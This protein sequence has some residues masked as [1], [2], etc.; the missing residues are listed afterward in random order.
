MHQG[1]L[2][3]QRATITVQAPAK[4][5][6]T[7]AITGLLNNG[8]HQVKTLMQSISLSDT[9]K[10][11]FSPAEGGSI[12]LYLDKGSDA[13]KELFPLDDSNLIVK[14][15]DHLLEK[16]GVKR[17]FDVK[18]EVKKVIPI[19]AGLAGGSSNAAASLVAVNRYLGNP[20]KSADLFKLAASLG[21]DVPFCLLGGTCIG[22]NIGDV[23]NIVENRS[24]LSFVLAKP[25]KLSVSTPLAYRLFDE[26]L[27]LGL[28]F[29][30]PNLEEAVT[31]LEFDEL[32]PLLSSMGNMF[33][34]V[35]LESYPQLK[36]LKK[37]ML[38]AGASLCQLTGSGPT[39]IAITKNKGEA[40]LVQENLSKLLAL[41]TMAGLEETDTWIAE[42][43]DSGTTIESE[44]VSP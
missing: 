26:R 33:E 6:L 18:I 11:N 34:P 13:N 42:T 14:A 29:P 28:P 38:E 31:A 25:S 8:Y 37:L 36:L 44:E 21:A 41:N 16:A 2:E 10:F 1:T 24:K 5:N 19:G 39:L 43:I 4:V 40:A 30:K 7:F 3:T 23:L 32:K 12:S 15:L 20:L 27:K 9:L 17:S 22:T 35:I